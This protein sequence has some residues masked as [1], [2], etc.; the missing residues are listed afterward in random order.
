MVT[1]VKNLVLIVVLLLVVSSYARFSIM[2]T[3]GVI[4]SICTKDKDLSSHCFE[5]LKPSSEIEK[6]DL[7]GLTKYLI[8]Y[9]TRN[10][11]NT[12][13]QLKLFAD[14]TTDF[15][16]HNMYLDCIEVY[17]GALYNNQFSLKDLAAKDYNGL[18]DRLGGVTTQMYECSDELVTIKP[19]PQSLIMKC[20]FIS[21]LS[22]I[23]LVILEYFIRKN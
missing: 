18:N 20:N 10:I 1:F 2:V 7:F 4:N 19:I 13:K 6:L 22:S 15:R 16:T 17:N 8:N 11:S 12:L 21:D 23:M 5:V 14:N 9:Q 3:K